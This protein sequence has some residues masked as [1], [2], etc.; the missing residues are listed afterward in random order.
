M[1][2]YTYIFMS[3]LIYFFRKMCFRLLVGPLLTAACKAT[4]GPSLL[5]KLHLRLSGILVS[6]CIVV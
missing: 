4:M 3:L 1:V 5:S 2:L 6:E